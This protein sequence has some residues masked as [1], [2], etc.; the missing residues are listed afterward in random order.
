LGFFEETY[1]TLQD[2]ALVVRGH[3]KRNELPT[4]EDVKL[5]KKMLFK[6]DERFRERYS[7]TNKDV[8]FIPQVA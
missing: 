6:M 7:L 4:M 2:L 5:W 3:E 8:V 1:G